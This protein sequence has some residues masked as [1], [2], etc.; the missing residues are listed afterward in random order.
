MAKI[1]ENLAIMAGKGDKKFANGR[2]SLVVFSLNMGFKP[3]CGKIIDIHEEPN[4]KFESLK[5]IEHADEPLIGEK[6]RLILASLKTDLIILRYSN[7]QISVVHKYKIM[8]H[9]ICS[10]ALFFGSSVFLSFNNSC[11]IEW[12]G[13]KS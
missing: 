5:L 11:A 10:G 1:D 2:P 8:S 3:I 12:Y 4:S 13:V 9:E 7:K 6:T